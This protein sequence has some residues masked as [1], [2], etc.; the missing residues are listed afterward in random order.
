MHQ[1]FNIQIKDVP[2]KDGLKRYP[3][4]S[5]YE[6][7]YSQIHV[8]IEHSGCSKMEISNHLK[9]FLEELRFEINQHLGL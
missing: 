2:N 1:Y 9:E 7:E 4:I 8:V 5:I 6:S 3:C